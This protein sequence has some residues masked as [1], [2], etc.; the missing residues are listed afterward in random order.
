MRDCKHGVGGVFLVATRKT[1]MVQFDSIQGRRH[2]IF[3]SI[4][5]IVTIFVHCS[6]DWESAYGMGID[7]WTT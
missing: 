6:F 7:R 4:T 2:R 5:L 1:K 3:M